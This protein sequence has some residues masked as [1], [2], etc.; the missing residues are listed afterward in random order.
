MIYKPVFLVVMFV[1]F[2]GMNRSNAQTVPCDCLT[3]IQDAVAVVM[4]LDGCDADG[5]WEA[6]KS[7][8]VHLAKLENWCAE[9]G[10]VKPWKSKIP[11]IF[12]GMLETIAD[13]RDGESYTDEFGNEVVVNIPAPGLALEA[14]NDLETLLNG[15]K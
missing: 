9:G 6:P 3:D 13:A 14:L 2:I 4:A 1:L 5:L 7:L 11:N 15:C 8:T 12:E 10:G